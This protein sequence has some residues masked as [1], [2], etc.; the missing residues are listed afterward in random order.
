MLKRYN[1]E[2]SYNPIMKR[3]T[4]VIQ[5]F[6]CI[7]HYLWLPKY[8]PIHVK[9]LLILILTDVD[10]IDIFD[11]NSR[12]FYFINEVLLKFQPTNIVGLISHAFV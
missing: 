6:T 2:L 10:Q 1:K 9:F 12:I 4:I 3:P 8:L 7:Y 11:L 5:H